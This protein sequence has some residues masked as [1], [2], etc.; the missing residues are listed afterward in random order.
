MKSTVALGLALVGAANAHYYI[1]DIDGST[2]CLR[3]LVQY[4]GNF[5]VTG[6]DIASSKIVCGANPASANPASGTCTYA[7]G[8]TM[9]VTYD[10]QVGHPGPCHVHA[11]QDGKNWALIY[12]DNVD[13]SPPTNPNQG[14][15]N[16]RFTNGQ[17]VFKYKIPAQLPAGKWVF[18]IEH[19]GL[20]GAGTSGGAQFYV[21]CADINITGGGTQL[22]GPTAQFPGDTYTLT[23]PAIL[24]NPYQGKNAQYPDFGPALAY[25]GSGGEPA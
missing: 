9:T 13:T 20:H 12:E 19:L 11:S 2:D 23:N 25:S 16:N 8:S 21:R 3:P 17:T 7:A 15:C 10:S 5:P 1:K 14:W 24:F 22:P 18:R 4:E 6:N